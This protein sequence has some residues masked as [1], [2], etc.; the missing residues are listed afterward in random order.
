MNK[1]HTPVSIIAS[2]FCA[3]QRVRWLEREKTLDDSKAC[4]V[5]T[6]C[7]YLRQNLE[8]DKELPLINL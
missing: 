3:Y 4:V 7:L 1:Y 5:L 2:Q 8:L 6:R